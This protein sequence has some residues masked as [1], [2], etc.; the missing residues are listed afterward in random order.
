MID[1]YG[2]GA[3]PILV[4]LT[5]AVTSVTSEVNVPRRGRAQARREIEDGDLV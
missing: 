4:G 1:L 5:A 2:K 3:L